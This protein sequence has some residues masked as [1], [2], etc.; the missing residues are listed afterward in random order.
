MDL[1]LSFFFPPCVV[2][3]LRQSFCTERERSSRPAFRNVSISRF[4]PGVWT[5][6][7]CLSVCAYFPFPASG[8]ERERSSARV[9]RGQSFG[10]V[11]IHG[12]SMASSSSSAISA[13]L[14]HI[15][16]R[17]TRWLPLCLPLRS[18]K[19]R[20]FPL[21]LCNCG[22][23]LPSACSRCAHTCRRSH[24]PGVGRRG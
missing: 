4:S 15:Q 11:H 17:L 1:F 13:G 6:C 7:V 16:I 21:S 24:W 20:R 10:Y 8:C 22:L 3:V 18:N 5:C 2:C 9:R 12:R 19:P 23:K 14:I